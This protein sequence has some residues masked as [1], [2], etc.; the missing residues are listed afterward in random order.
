MGYFGLD[1]LVVLVPLDEQC[2]LADAAVSLDHE[3]VVL[4]GAVGHH[5]EPLFDHEIVFFEAVAL[6]VF[7]EV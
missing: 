1:G 2:L 5:V 6:F 7:V 3:R 4:L